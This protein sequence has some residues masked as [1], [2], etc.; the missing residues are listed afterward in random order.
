MADTSIYTDSIANKPVPTA[1]QLINKSVAGQKSYL[2]K[3][4]Y[5]ND[6]VYGHVGFNNNG[7][8]YIDP[9]QQEKFDLW[10]TEVNY[11][12]AMKG[13]DATSRYYKKYYAQAY[14]LLPVSVRGTTINE[15]EYSLLASFI[16]E[17]QTDLTTDHNNLLLLDIP[18]AG[19]KAVGFIES[20]VGGVQSNNQGIPVA[21]EFEFSFVVVENLNDYKDTHDDGI[22]SFSEVMYLTSSKE[23]V[24]LVT[25]ESFQLQV[26]Y[27]GAGIPGDIKPAKNPRPPSNTGSTGVANNAINSG[28]N[29][30]RGGAR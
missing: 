26:M 27:K 1:D 15:K 12:H 25:D 10:V 13:I 7:G 20:F 8:S 22:R 5:N 24:V 23:N 28:T 2:R 16:R 4:N 17:Q 29:S 3:L 14:H 30:S 18:A 21:P 9:Q 19:I 11:G 6:D